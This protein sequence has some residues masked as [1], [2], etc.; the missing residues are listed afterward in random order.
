MTTRTER[1]WRGLL[2]VSV[3]LILV[4]LALGAGA[5]QG[6]RESFSLKG[7]SF[8]VICPNQGSL[9]RLLV[10]AGRDGQT[11]AQAEEDVEGTVTGAAAADLNRD[12][13]PEIYVFVTSA[14]SGSYGALV[15]FTLANQGA[16][17]LTRIDLPSL[18]DDPENSRGYM[19]HD[20]FQVEG[21]YL[22]RRF[23]VYRPGENNA[24]PG[25]GVRRIRYRLVGNSQ[26]WRLVV[27]DSMLEGVSSAD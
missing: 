12:G 20:R 3:L 1:G 11:P 5:P 18:E 25:G 4:S 22:V 23:P 7:A 15:A 17:G 14:G 13:L 24:D 21:S 2:I 27:Q 9:N 16:S 8:K 6:F 19:G 10:E 26:G